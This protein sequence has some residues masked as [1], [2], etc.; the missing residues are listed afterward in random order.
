MDSVDSAADV[1]I[2]HKN[3]LSRLGAMF[4]HCRAGSA[5]PLKA[6]DHDRKAERLL[7]RSLSAFDM[8]GCSEAL[9]R[10]RYQMVC[11]QWP[12][13]YW[14]FL[15]GAAPPTLSFQTLVQQLCGFS[16]HSRIIVVAYLKKIHGASPFRNR[17]IE[18]AG[19]FH[20]QHIGLP[21]GS[22]ICCDVLISALHE[23]CRPLASYFSNRYRRYP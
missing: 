5:S 23:N 17:L 7:Y 9:N 8:D 13:A 4:F 15:S 10:G 3:R 6:G 12:N 1:R 16:V 22:P 11:S 19:K 20:S 18:S 21:P 14:I 2:P